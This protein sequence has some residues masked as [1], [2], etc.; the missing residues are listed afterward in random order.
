MDVDQKNIKYKNVTKNNIFVT[1]S[2][3][4]KIKEEK[5]RNMGR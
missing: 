5:K 2:E 4:C 3:K 1:D